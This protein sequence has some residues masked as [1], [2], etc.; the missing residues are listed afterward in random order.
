MGTDTETTCGLCDRK[1]RNPYNL[2]KHMKSHRSERINPFNGQ[3]T[4][5]SEKTYNC[6]LCNFKT[7]W[8]HIIRKHAKNHNSGNIKKRNAGEKPFE[9]TYCSKSFREN[10]YLKSHMKIHTG[11]KDFKCE[12]EG[13]DKAYRTKKE[14]R[15]HNMRHTGEK[16]E[17]CSY[18]GKSF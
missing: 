17:V 2:K 11:T 13:C 7:T 8:P 12:V 16:S 4:Y 10:Y 5:I 18:C 3:K 15:S 14:L 6:K 9:C 1:F